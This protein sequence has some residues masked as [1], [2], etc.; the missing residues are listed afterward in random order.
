MSA[1]LSDYIRC[2]EI[3]Y[4][5]AEKLVNRLHDNDVIIDTYK[6]EPDV[7]VEYKGNAPCQQVVHKADDPDFN[8][9]D[10]W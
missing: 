10:M 5:D 1:S 2:I 7:E 4:K 9:E 3:N 8:R 6:Y